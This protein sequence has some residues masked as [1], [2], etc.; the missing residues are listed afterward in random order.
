MNYG[1][2][3]KWVHILSSTVL[4]GTGLGTAYFMWMAHLSRSPTIIAYTATQVVRADFLFTTT[5]G[6]IQPITGILLANHIGY[7]LTSPWLIG[8]YC[9]YAL[10]LLC[11]LPVVWLQIKM[12]N[13]AMN[14]KIRSAELPASYYTYTKVWFMLGWPAFMSL[15]T[16]FYLMIVKPN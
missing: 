16:I 15:I 11:W 13:L 10:A 4:F 1:D 12:R 6:L 3:L 9:L 14:A 2:V 7:D 8:T 5:S